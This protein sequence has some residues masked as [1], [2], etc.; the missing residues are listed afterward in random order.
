MKIGIYL[1]EALSALML[2]LFCLNFGIAQEGGSVTPPQ[3]IKT[4]WGSHEMDTENHCVKLGSDNI[5]HL[6]I[7]VTT[8]TD[9]LDSQL[10]L[11]VYYN[12]LGT[13]LSDYVQITSLQMINYFGFYVATINLE[14]DLSSICALNEGRGNPS[15]TFL[16]QLVTPDANSPTGYRP[17]PTNNQYLWPSNFFGLLPAAD[18][19]HSV[20]KDICCSYSSGR[21]LVVI[22]NDG[23]NIEIASAETI[24]S[25]SDEDYDA[26]LLD[27]NLKSTS[28]SDEITISPNPFNEGLNVQF[29]LEEASNV[30]IE[31][32]DAQGKVIKSFSDTVTSTGQSTM[33]LELSS[34]PIGF[35]YLRVSTKKWT[36][37][38]KVVKVVN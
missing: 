8:I 36:N 4:N 24:K 38:V 2:T 12:L 26:Q 33:R 20:T 32:L 23:N 15:F 14:D 11:Y 37:T 27:N 35:Y 1:K 6:N 17:Y 7:Y 13:G 21:E 29:A 19:L 31:C 22:A 28:F 18:P 10:P 16:T 25:V 9:D 30:K 5:L 34:I 3:P